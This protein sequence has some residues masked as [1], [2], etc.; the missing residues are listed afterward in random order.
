VLSIVIFA[1]SMSSYW[2]YRGG[3]WVNFVSI[4][5]FLQALFWGVLHMFN[6][7]PQILGNYLI[8]LI[9]CVLFTVFYLIAGIVAACYASLF[10]AVGVASFFSFVCIV[11]FGVDAYFQ[12]VRVRQPASEVPNQHIEPAVSVSSGNEK[13]VY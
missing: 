2:G 7:I 12:F 1:L 11:A 4:N 9:I 5:G 10:P 13:V 6:A 8:E 3:H